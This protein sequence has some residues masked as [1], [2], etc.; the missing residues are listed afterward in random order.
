MF[1]QVNQKYADFDTAT[2]VGMA[3]WLTCPSASG[4]ANHSDYVRLIKAL[5]EFDGAHID[6][7]VTLA[8]VLT[9]RQKALMSL[10]YF[11]GDFAGTIG[12]MTILWTL[13]L[14]KKSTFITF[15]MI[16][17][18]TDTEGVINFI[19]LTVIPALLDEMSQILTI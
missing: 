14:Y 12:E 6:S 11:A 9:L 3:N 19:L 15:G 4:M 1:I 17:L 2:Q 16:I 7:M 5:A 13:S 18:G 10:V 8:L